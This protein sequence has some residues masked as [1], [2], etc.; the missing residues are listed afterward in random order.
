LDYETLKTTL[1]TWLTPEESEDEVPVEEIE[2]VEEVVEAEVAPVTPAKNYAL[3]TP[4]AT[5]A[6]SKAEKFDSLFDDEISDDD[7]PF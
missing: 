7:L 5:K 6:S 2:E 3:K 1:Q 4:V